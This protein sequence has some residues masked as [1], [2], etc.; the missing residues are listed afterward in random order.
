MPANKTSQ[1]SWDQASDLHS[2][3][4]FISAMRLA[5]TLIAEKHN[6][7]TSSDTNLIS[8]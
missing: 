5:I 8:G 6:A 1:G 3:C 2:R 4:P 7:M